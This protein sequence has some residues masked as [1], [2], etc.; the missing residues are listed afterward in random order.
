MRVRVTY[1]Y[2]CMWAAVLVGASFASHPLVIV[3]TVVALAIAAMI[4]SRYK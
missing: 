3:V 2:M 4:C 1:V